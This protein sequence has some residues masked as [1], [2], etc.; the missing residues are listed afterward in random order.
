M[1]ITKKAQ[2]KKNRRKNEK[3]L[4]KEALHNFK[5][6]IN[7]FARDICQLCRMAY[8]I[9][10]HHP[11]YGCRGADKDDRVL[12]LVCRSCHDKCHKEKH[13]EWNTKAKQIGNKNWEKH[14]A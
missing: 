11:V 5:M 13:G 9:E 8:G 6:D 14:N 3:R 1:M 4:D 10:H 12:V 7:F 2:L